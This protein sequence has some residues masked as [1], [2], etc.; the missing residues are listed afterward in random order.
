MSNSS[1]DESTEIAFFRRASQY[2]VA[3]RYATIAQLFPVCA[4]LLHHA[5]EMYLKG[6]LSRHCSLD[7]LKSM[8]HN[9]KKTWRTFKTYFPN[10]N[11]Q[12]FDASVSALHK[13]ER[14]RYPDE[15][16]VNGICGQLV[17]FRTDIVEVQPFGKSP[18][19]VFTL[20][21][22]DIDQLVKYLFEIARVNPNFYFNNSLNQVAHY[23][24]IERNAYPILPTG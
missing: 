4:N 2:Y 18:S 23:Y 21:L 19:P 6:V 3:G 5:L 15:E 24:L 22:E 9:L 10:E 11:L 20:V 7:E 14:L 13:F 16:I 8:N 17:L 1:A 12:K